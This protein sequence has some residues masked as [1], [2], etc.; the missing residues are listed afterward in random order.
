MLYCPAGKLALLD[1]GAATAEQLQALKQHPSLQHAFTVY[2]SRP[3]ALKASLAASPEAM[4]QQLASLD[5][6]LQAVAAA[7][8]LVQVGTHSSIPHVR[9][10][11]KVKAT[12][13]AACCLAGLPYL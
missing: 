6:A 11:N 3:A 4:E 10:Q 12:E 1:V 13:C 9:L 8:G 2:V 5:P 7:A